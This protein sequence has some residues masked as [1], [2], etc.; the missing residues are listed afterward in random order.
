MSWSPGRT[1]KDLEKEAIEQA[2]TFY[3]GN[4]TQTAVSLGICVNTLNTRLAEYAEHKIGYNPPNPGTEIGNGT[5]REKTGEG[6]SPAQEVSETQSRVPVESATKIPQK[7][8]M[9][10]RK[11]AEV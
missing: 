4:K 1:I 7:Q 8:Q 10:M 9:P 5:V 2:M 6:N 11:R 3:H